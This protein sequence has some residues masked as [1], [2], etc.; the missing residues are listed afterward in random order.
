MRKSVFVSRPRRRKASRNCPSAAS[1]RTGRRRGIAR[2][3]PTREDAL[4]RRIRV[5]AGHGQVME[6]ETLLAGERVNP[7]QH[8]LDGRRFVD[9]KAG[10]EISANVPR[11]PMWPKPRCWTTAFMPRYMKRPGMKQCCPVALAGG[12][13]SACARTRSPPR[14]CRTPGSA[15]TARRLPAPALALPGV[16]HGGGG[17]RARAHAEHFPA[18]EGCRAALFHSGR[19]MYL[20][21]NAVIQQRG[22]ETLADAGDHRRQ[23]QLELRRGRTG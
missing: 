10:I 23:L 12:Q 3:R 16:R 13:C 18:G 20:G 19:F 7:R 22:F 11:L 2:R 8:P 9:A 21:M 4:R 17:L 6:K 15:S 14:P 1:R 5:M